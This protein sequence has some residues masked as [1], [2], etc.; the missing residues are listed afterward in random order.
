[1]AESLMFSVSEVERFG[2]DVAVTLYPVQ[3]A[4]ANTEAV[5]EEERVHRA[6]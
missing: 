6:G 4:G 2:E 3:D 5:V 1:M